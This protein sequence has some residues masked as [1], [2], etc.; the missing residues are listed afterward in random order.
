MRSADRAL[1]EG[2]S[3]FVDSSLCPEPE[4]VAVAGEDFSQATDELVS[5][6]S[7][8]GD[9]RAD[10]FEALVEDAFA[11]EAQAPQ[12]RRSGR[13]R[14]PSARLAHERR[15]RGLG[16][17]VA[18]A[19]LLSAGLVGIAL[20]QPEQG[21]TT[22]ELPAKPFRAIQSP[23][24]IKV[25][26]APSVPVVPVEVPGEEPEEQPEASW[27]EPSSSQPRQ[28]V[29]EAPEVSPA[30]SHTRV[31]PAPSQE[32]RPEP[33]P[34]ASPQPEPSEPQEATSEPEATPSP[35]PTA[36]P[37]SP[38]DVMLSVASAEGL[39]VRVP[40]ERRF[41]AFE[42]GDLPQGAILRS[43]RGGARVALPSGTLFL[44]QEGEVEWR[45][46]LQLTRGQVLLEGRALRV[47]SAQGAVDVRGRALL[48]VRKGKLGVQVLAGEARWVR[49]QDQQ[50]MSAGD[51]L[52]ASG[53]GAP[54]VGRGKG[55]GPQAAPAWVRKLRVARRRAGRKGGPGVGP[56]GSGPRKSG[57]GP[58]GRRGGG[59]SR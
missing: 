45:E 38:E 51:V 11:V 52:M 4:E 43:Q 34:V 24:P 28:P 56:G 53:K 30:P 1:A 57:G 12:R 33:A 9:C 23:S 59:R 14:R 25:A 10:L 41:Q 58:G 48:E 15:Q 19:G 2:L 21:S 39:F 20:F 7:A 26:P 16:W 37:A 49:G 18:A 5:H 31:E 29:V 22:A 35:M 27:P 42:S 8:C 55:T 3:R 54:R 36:E 13:V 44:A 17:A 32:P 6:L 46:G 47:L 40:G 50:D